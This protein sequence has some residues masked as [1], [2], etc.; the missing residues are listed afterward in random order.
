M[1]CDARSSLFRIHA[2]HITHRSICIGDKINASDVPPNSTRAR[3]LM[4]RVWIVAPRKGFEPVRLKGHW[5]SSPP[6]YVMGGVRD[7]R[8]QS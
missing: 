1:S 8:W 7:V 6:R 4:S 2:S 3:A 5:F